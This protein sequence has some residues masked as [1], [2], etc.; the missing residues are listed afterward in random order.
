MSTAFNQVAALYDEA[1]PGYPEPLIEDV[2]GLSAIPPGGRILEI[3]SGTGQATLPFAR[4]GYT[5]LCLEPGDALARIAS[6]HCL[7]Y[8]L[9]SIQLVTFEDWP[10]LRSAFDL[11]ISAQA[12][13]WIPAEIGYPKAAATLKDSGSLALFWNRSPDVDTPF[14]QAVEEVFRNKA[15]HLMEYL[16][17]KESLE[18]WINQKREQIESSGQFS[19]VTI[20]VYPWSEKYT[21]ER[22]IKLL[23]TFSVISTLEESSRQELLAEL[24]DTANRFGSEV[25]SPHLSILFIANKQ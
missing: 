1:R 10:L 9:V 15:P 23:K 2:V 5:M 17:G 20:K 12:F 4:K 21:V 16:P 19:E 25:D 7:S 22:Y 18:D 8:P 6:R 14:R 11:V 13:D 24:R 3:G